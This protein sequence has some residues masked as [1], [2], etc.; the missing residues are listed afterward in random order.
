MPVKRAIGERGKP[1][2]KA[3]TEEGVPPLP[4]TRKA[5][6]P[7]SAA[8]KRALSAA[9]AR[10]PAPAPA[11]APTPTPTPTPVAAPTTPRAQVA[12]TQPVHDRGFSPSMQA[13]TPSA[14]TGSDGMAIAPLGPTVGAPGLGIDSSVIAFMREERDFMAAQMKEQK[15]EVERQRKEMERQMKEMEA[16]LSPVAA[17]SGEQLIRLQARLEKLHAAKLLT[18]DELFAMEVRTAD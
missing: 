17:I 12:L 2:S 8:P 18:D 9:P 11:P 6:A 4:S 15:E 3:S 14:T 16:N 1:K 13:V 5:P 10:P 7:A